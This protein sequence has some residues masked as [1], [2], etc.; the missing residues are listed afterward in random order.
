MM[1]QLSADN[2]CR[3]SCCGTTQAVV[4]AP[5]RKNMYKG[6]SLCYGIITGCYILIGV[7]GY[8]SFGNQAQV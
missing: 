2:E 8:W 5:V 6:V 7:V 1:C 4:D 3:A